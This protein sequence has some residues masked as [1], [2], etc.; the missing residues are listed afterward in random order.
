MADKAA[1]MDDIAAAQ[2]EIQEIRDLV[3]DLKQRIVAAERT[4]RRL[5]DRRRDHP[6]PDLEQF[7]SESDRKIQWNSIGKCSKIPSS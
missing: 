3:S 6:Q 4:H 7:R 5:R 2:Q 1:F